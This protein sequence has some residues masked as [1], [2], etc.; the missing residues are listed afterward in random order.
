MGASLG[1]GRG[2]GEGVVEGSWGGGCGRRIGGLGRGIVEGFLE[3][4]WGRDWGEELGKHLSESLESLSSKETRA[5]E[6][7]F[8]FTSKPPSAEAKKEKTV[9]FSPCLLRKGTHYF[10]S[11]GTK[12]E[13]LEQVSQLYFYCLKTPS[14]SLHMPSSGLPPRRLSLSTSRV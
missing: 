12:N 9:L 10:L 3:G 1:V 13:T 2:V 5:H 11:P 6:G 4:S 8:A 7:S 14:T